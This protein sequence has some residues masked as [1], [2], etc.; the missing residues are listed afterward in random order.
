MVNAKPFYLAIISIAIGGM[1]WQ[2]G[3]FGDLF[4]AQAPGDQ[5]DSADSIN[6]SAEDSALQGNFTGDANPQSGN[7]VGLIISGGQ[8]IM[9]MAGLV[10]WL[11]YEL[12]ALGLPPWAAD[13]LG[14]LAVIIMSI[15]IIQ[16]II[17]RYL[18]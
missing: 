7:L 17:G 1:I 11:P 2:L 4:M 8:E 5:L 18:R 15:G 10:V 3:G 14:K 6:E 9:R 16:M 12:I 13:P